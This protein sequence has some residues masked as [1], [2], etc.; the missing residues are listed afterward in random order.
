MH[1]SRT[2]HLS[3]PQESSIFKI[4]AA[5]I[6]VITILAIVGL[7][8]LLR[9]DRYIANRSLWLDE[10]MLAFNIVNRSFRELLQP[11]DYNQGAPLGF[12]FI[13]KASISLLGNNEYVLRLFPLFA[14]IILIILFYRLTS[15]LFA[16]LGVLLAITLLIVNERLIYYS[17]E[18]KQYSSDLAIVVLLFLLTIPL[19]QFGEVKLMRYLLWGSLAGFCL[20]ISHPA[21]FALVGI[22]TGL[23]IQYLIK[24]DWLKLKWLTMGMLIWLINFLLIYLI[25]LQILS[26]NAILKDFWSKYFM[27]IPPWGNISWFRFAVC[28]MLMVPVSLSTCKLG[29]LLFVIGAFSFFISRWNW[30]L[31]LVLPFFFTLLASGLHLYPFGHRLLLFIVP[32]VLILITEGV[33]RIRLLTSKFR[34]LSLG[35]WGVI[36]LLLLSTPISL[37][38]RNYVRPPMIEHIKPVLAYIQDQSLPGDLIC[39]DM[40]A[41]PAYDYY[42]PIYGIPDDPCILDVS[43]L[44]NNSEEY[45]RQLNKQAGNGRA[46]FIFSHRDDRSKFNG[47]RIFLDS[48]DRFGEK[49]D[50]IKSQGASAYLVY[51]KSL[52]G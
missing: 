13:E 7:G 3:D 40:G 14:G 32:L 15:Y 17:S 1:N 51:L 6:P 11:L 4:V 18:V 48:L 31:I 25:S 26:T 39:V 33:E 42:A 27:P 37:A 20:W 46:W 45:S 10:A 2:I 22:S 16:P 47:K 52:G 30:G 24:K 23:V 36:A 34:W 12:L 43:S 44:L 21:F 5:R 9:I 41:K 29:G 28:D 50:E 38:Y 49:L 19:T 8:I 35:S